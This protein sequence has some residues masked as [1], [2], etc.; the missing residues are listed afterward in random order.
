MALPIPEADQSFNESGYRTICVSG[1]TRIAVR[2]NPVHKKG[3]RAVK[4]PSS[5]MNSINY[6]PTMYGQRLIN[7]SPSPASIQKPSQPK[8]TIKANAATRKERHQFYDNS[9]NKSFEKI[10]KYTDYMNPTFA[11]NK[12]TSYLTK[13]QK[14][15]AAEKAICATFDNGTSPQNSHTFD[16]TGTE[17]KTENL[18]FTRT[19]DKTT[20]FVA[21]RTDDRA[22]IAQLLKKPHDSPRGKKYTNNGYHDPCC[23]PVVSLKAPSGSR[24][25]APPSRRAGKRGSQRPGEVTIQ[26]VDI[27]HKPGTIE[28]TQAQ[29]SKFVQ[30]VVCSRVSPTESHALSHMNNVHG[31]NRRSPPP[32]PFSHDK[33][34][35]VR[36]YDKRERLM[37]NNYYRRNFNAFSKNKGQ[38]QIRLQVDHLWSS[39]LKRADKVMAGCITDKNS[40]RRYAIGAVENWNIKRSIAAE[41]PRASLERGVANHKLDTRAEEAKEDVDEEELYR[42]ILEERFKEEIKKLV[43]LQKKRKREKKLYKN[44]NKTYDRIKE[45]K[46]K[47][48]LRSHFLN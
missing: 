10:L 25:V 34:P 15:Q 43:E 18:T 12:T 11:N 38:K 35:K 33:P 29:L 7:E 27:S 5:L 6:S 39:A 2:R 30:S 26:I 46:N 28:Y 3:S 44:T 9:S 40:G 47:D 1:I 16:R 21:S 48:Y 37:I 4:V 22:V 13:I 14:K 42:L 17:D 20:S 19:E 24:S 31:N 45:E 36:W 32:L 23:L 41:S 8:S